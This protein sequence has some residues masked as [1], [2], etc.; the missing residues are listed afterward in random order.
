[1]L[2]LLFFFSFQ[3]PCTDWSAFYADLPDWPATENVLS[4]TGHLNVLLLDPLCPLSDEF[5][6]AATLNNWF[7]LYEEEL[8]PDQMESWDINLTN[9]GYMTLM[10]YTSS[11]FE[12]CRGIMVFKEIEG[13][14]IA[15]TRVMASNRA[16]TGAPSSL[17]SLGGI[18]IRTPRTTT[19]ATW[20]P[21][22]ENYIFL[23]T[24]SADTPGTFQFEVKTTEDSNSFLEIDDV[25]PEMPGSDC[26]A[27]PEITL[28]GVRIGHHF[29]MLRKRDSGDWEVHRRYPRADM[30][31]V[32][33][34]GFTTYTDWG[35]I[36]ARYWPEDVPGYNNT[37]ITDGNPDLVA[38]FDYLRYQRPQVPVALQGRDFSAPYNP[39]DPQTVSDAELL[40]FL[41][42]D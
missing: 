34:V 21:G 30:P 35:T 32:L 40:S 1:M 27:I 14:F 22:G 20:V 38:R 9:P 2:P 5:D 41:G 25:C 13:D 39:N 33:Q 42:F 11:W 12:D 26:G 8:W 19:S 17:Y 4:L 23:S 29:L 7:R 16:G 28:R 31:P 15:S 36:D 24:G 37:V 10:P 18:L 3:A 6:D